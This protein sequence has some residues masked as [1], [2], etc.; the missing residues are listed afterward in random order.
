MTKDNAS[1]KNDNWISRFG[2][3]EDVTERTGA[4]GKFITFKLQAKSF[5]QYG[6][7]FDEKVMEEMKAA[8]G[9]D[10]W[11]KGP[12]DT[13]SGRDADGKPREMKSFKVVFFKI[14]E[15][16]A[17]NADAGQSEAA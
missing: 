11:V 5:I 16:R 3:L 12:V 9:K 17:E 1:A 13:H 15:P 14:S 6:A 8:V 2:I 10:V 7:C 4:K